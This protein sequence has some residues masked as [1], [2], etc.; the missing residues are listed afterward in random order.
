MLVLGLSPAHAEDWSGHASVEFRGFFREPLFPEQ[1]RANI[2]LSLQPEFY[3][4]N[5]EGS[6]SILI[7]PFGRLDQSDPERT[8]FDIRELIWQKVDD[9]WE[10]RA[11]I[12]KVFW[13]VTE[14]QH[15]VDIIN[16]T[17]QVENIDGEDKLGQPM[18]NL[19]MIRSWG[20]VDLF[21]LPGFRK[22][23][24]PGPKGRLRFPLRVATDLTQ[25]ESSAEEKHVDMAVRWSHFIGD[26][27]IG[28][29]HFYGTSREPTFLS[30]VD[31]IGELVLI[32]RYDLINQTGLDVQATK[33]AWLW[34][35]ELM[36]RSG[37]GDRFN[38]LTGGFEYTFT[39]LWDSVD[40]GILFEY[41]FDSRGVSINTPF[42]DDVFVATRLAFNDAQS[43]EFLLGTILDRKTGASFVN[44]EGNRRLG[45]RWT[46]NVELRA[47]LGIPENDPFFGFRNDDH[48]QLELMRYF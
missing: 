25:F 23:T 24:F 37:Q 9:S 39:N 22:R 20:T 46:F 10:V 32:P 29:S 33:G 8:H 3:W 44:V 21:V 35:L 28:L 34:K 11:G 26:W 48:I 15:L 7:V 40:L 17:D 12:G 16:Q 36:M 1:S 47:F 27:D 4:E 43:T 45:D 38:A 42:Q 14:S 19:A 13:G 41:L 2:S 30:G 31:A 5:A 18:V 6:Q